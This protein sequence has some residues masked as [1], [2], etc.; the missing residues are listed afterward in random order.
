MTKPTTI[1]AYIAQFDEPIAIRLCEL[2]TIIQQLIPEATETIS[3]GMPAFKLNS[4]V[5]YFAGY[6]HHIGFYP[7]AEPIQAFANQLKNYKT[8]KGAIQFQLDKPLPQKLITD[9]IKYRLSEM[10]KKPS[11]R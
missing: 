1:D 8:S 6:K 4:N 11:K 9:I 5:V 7:H 2:K 10:Q 3:Y